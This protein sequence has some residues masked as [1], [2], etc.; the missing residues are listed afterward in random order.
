[1]RFITWVY[2]DAQ[3]LCTPKLSLPTKS[4]LGSYQENWHAQVK[5]PVSLGWLGA[6][7]K[8]AHPWA[9]PKACL[10]GEDIFVSL[11]YNFRLLIP[12]VKNLANQKQT[13]KNHRKPCIHSFLVIFFYSL[14]QI[15]QAVFRIHLPNTLFLLCI[16]NYF[17]FYDWASSSHWS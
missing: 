17:L 1:M 5:K 16:F 15:S 3:H 12:Q 9:S 11:A 7:M 13:S 8:T 10:S 14:F 6:L 2:V 4:H